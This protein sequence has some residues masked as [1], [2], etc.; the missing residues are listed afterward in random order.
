VRGRGAAHLNLTDVNL[1]VLLAE[2]LVRL[3]HR[4]ERHHG[5]AQVLRR[6]RGAL[7]V[8]GLLRELRELRLVHAL[9]LERAQGAL[10]DRVLIF[11]SVSVSG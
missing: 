1:A 11:V 9:L 7:D 6:E 2:L 4:V 8:E 10:L 5:V 3:R